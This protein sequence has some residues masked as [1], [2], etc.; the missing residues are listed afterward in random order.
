MATREHADDTRSRLLHAAEQLF[1]EGGHDALSLRRVTA[2]A[3]ANLAAVNYHFGGKEAMLHELLELRLGPLNAERLR[4]LDACEAGGRAPDHET[5]L[6]VL[7]VPALRIGRS[8][9][10]GPAFL[11]LLGRVYSDASP[12][13][14]DYLQEHYRPIFERFFEAFA[15]ALPRIPR[16]ELGLRLDFALKALS[17]VLATDD[18]GELI[19]KLSMGQ[20]LGDAAL[21]ARLVALV[22]PALVAPLGEPHQV[23]RMDSLLRQDAGLAQ[24]PAPRA[25]GQVSAR[26]RGSR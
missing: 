21:L 24:A 18:M 1:I 12:F 4:L 20:P 25:S 11:R 8:P 14:R 16:N 26:G 5:I 9:G 2:R 13:V 17:G 23:E 6:G 7:F 3:G 19:A 15:R 10:G 22:S